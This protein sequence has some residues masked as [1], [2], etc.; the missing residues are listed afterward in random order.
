MEE[1]SLQIYLF[2][3]LK[4]VFNQITLQIRKIES[5]IV[6]YR[7]NRLKNIK[8]PFLLEYKDSIVVE[9]DTYIVIINNNFW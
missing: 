9:K 1:K 6:I 3:Y 2:Q 8:H 4:L 5:I 7:M